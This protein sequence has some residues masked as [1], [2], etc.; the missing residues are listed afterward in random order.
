M[1]AIKAIVSFAAE[2]QTVATHCRRGESAQSCIAALGEVS[3]E[4][5]NYPCQGGGSAE[6]DK[7]YGEIECPAGLA[8]AFLDDRTFMWVGLARIRHVCFS[9]D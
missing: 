6:T 1:I 8:E 4:K 7:P 2:L 5:Q 9:S 3:R